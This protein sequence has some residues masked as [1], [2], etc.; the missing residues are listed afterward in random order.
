MRIGIIGGGLS[1]LACARRLKERGA[2]VAVFDK[3]RGPGGRMSSR[4]AGDL[5]FDHGAQYFTARSDAFRQQVAA[6][7]AAGAVAPWDGRFAMHDNGRLSA[8]DPADVRWVGTPKM[9]AVVAHEAS[10]LNTVFGCRIRSLSRDHDL[11]TLTDTE[12]GL[13]GPYD[14][15]VLALPA[16]Q[17]APML[18]G[19]SGLAE[20]A[21]AARSSPC[22]T[23]MAGFDAPLDVP[24]DGI[25]SV[26]GAV[27]WAA[28]NSSKPGRPD[29]ECWVVHASPDWS[30]A[31]L[32]DDP[33]DITKRLLEAFCALT[34][35]VVPAPVHSAAHRWR[36][37]LVTQVTGTPFGLDAEQAL[38]V[39]GDWRL[40]PRVELAWESGDAL[41]R[42][43][44]I[45]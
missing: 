1:G 33:E 18:K 22:W 26:Q 10:L 30:E 44:S 21:A 39:C 9:N 38:S 4:R 13:H 45:P 27:S 3:G 5:L 31:H 34:G 35:T 20:E 29:A 28:R 40:G 17:A 8:E 43:L 14:H 16:E 19:L 36:Y 24:F 23:L 11:W 15:V 25:R 41:G 37:A 42:A 32:E 12:G 2:Q 6:W 7:Q